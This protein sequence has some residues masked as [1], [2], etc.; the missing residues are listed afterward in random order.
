MILST[1]LIE[2]HVWGQHD[3]IKQAFLNKVTKSGVVSKESTL[4]CIQQ[5]E[6]Q[7]SKYLF[8]VL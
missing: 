4:D 3:F 5:V 6:A 2:T 7:W 8:D 1:F